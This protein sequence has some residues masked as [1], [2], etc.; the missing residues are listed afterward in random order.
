MA[1]TFVELGTLLPPFHAVVANEFK[2]SNLVQDGLRPA[3][4]T[5]L[6]NL[7]LPKFQEL[8]LMMEGMWASAQQRTLTS[9]Q[10][11]AILSQLASGTLFNALRVP[12]RESETPN[13][14]IAS[15]SLRQEVRVVRFL[16]YA[17][18]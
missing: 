15:D 4:L 18:L 2:L 1:M 12:G 10:V 14:S 6:G 7:P 8:W 3:A 11:H 9:V 16:L 17:G 13:T 5:T